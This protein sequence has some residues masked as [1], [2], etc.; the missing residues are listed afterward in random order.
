MSEG[1]L[2]KFRCGAS[3]KHRILKWNVNRSEKS[4][5]GKV[6]WLAPGGQKAR[7]G[8]G[9]PFPVPQLLGEWSRAIHLSW[10]A[11]IHCSSFII[12]RSHT[13]PGLATVSVS[14]KQDE[15]E[16]STRSWRRRRI[17]DG[18]HGRVK[19]KPNTLQGVKAGRPRQRRRQRSNSIFI[20]GNYLRCDKKERFDWLAQSCVPKDEARCLEK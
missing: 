2:A 20:V 13:G 7:S 16:R 19:S 3:L 10:F 8:T 1:T 5:E 4:V 9:V 11:V 12:R 14:S 18:G 6:H 17:K 15:D